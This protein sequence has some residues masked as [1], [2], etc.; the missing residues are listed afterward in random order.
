LGALAASVVPNR[1]LTWSA[2]GNFGQICFDL[3]QNMIFLASTCVKACGPDLT[4][5]SNGG[6]FPAAPE[7]INSEPETINSNGTSLFL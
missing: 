4:S 3:L 5:M 2:P 6:G 7:T 1:P